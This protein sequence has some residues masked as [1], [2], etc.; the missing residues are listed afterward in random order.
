MA[1]NSLEVVILPSSKPGDPGNS[2]VH[3]G[4]FLGLNNQGGGSGAGDSLW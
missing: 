2:P 1:E 4:N 3:P